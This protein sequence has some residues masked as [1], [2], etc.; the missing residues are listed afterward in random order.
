MGL[1]ESWNKLTWFVKLTS[2]PFYLLGVLIDVFFQIVPATIIFFDT[3]RELL[4]TQRLERYK[5]DNNWRTK[6]AVFICKNFLDPFQA[7]GHCN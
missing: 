6:V 7:G 1:R 4:F 2:A 3:P 5:K